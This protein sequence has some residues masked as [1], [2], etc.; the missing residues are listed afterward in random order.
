MKYQIEKVAS[1]FIVKAEDEDEIPGGTSDTT[2]G[3]NHF[4]ISFDLS[5]KCTEDEITDA[6][7]NMDYMD[8]EAEMTGLNVT[9][10]ED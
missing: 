6:F 8:G 1:G 7:H 3:L 4:K 9:A 2:T 10:V 5:T